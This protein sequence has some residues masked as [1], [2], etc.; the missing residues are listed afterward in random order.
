[1]PLTT[2]SLMQI[3]LDM[4]GWENFP[5]DCGVHVPAERVT[6]LLAGLDIDTGDLLLA[7]DL[8][9]DAV[10]AY[11]CT[12][13]EAELTAWQVCHRH[14][15]L[16]TA[17]GVPRYAAEEAVLD[18]IDTLR[19]ATHTANYERVSGAAHLAGMP[20]LNIKSPVDELG[21]RAMQRAVDDLLRPDN[22]AT[23][24]EVCA[25]LSASFVEFQHAPTQITVPLGNAEEPAGRTVVVHGAS[26]DAG[27][28]IG[29]AYFN[30]GIDTIIYVNIAPEELQTL[31]LI[32]RGN[33][34]VTGRVASVSIGLNLYLEALE[35]RGVEVTRLNGVL[36][37]T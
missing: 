5:G 36:P 35:A 10:L 11:E 8:G 17:A 32:E 26:L 6:T 4:A 31:R 33:L 29:R 7:R 1:M 19:H 37:S 23:L 13:T 2:D 27:A 18:Q 15:E 20:F 25:H 24:A 12:G 28:A 22:E 34:I 3:A 14:I 9:Y 21:R 16:L 30:H